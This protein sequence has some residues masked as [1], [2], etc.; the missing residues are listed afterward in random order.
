MPA[1]S[2]RGTIF[3]D[4][5]GL[6]GRP[7]LMPNPWDVYTARLFEAEGYQALGTSSA[8]AAW[9]IGRRDGRLLRDEA[10]AHARSIAAAVTVPVSAD[11]ENGFSDRPEDLTELMRLASEAGLAG[12]S[13]EDATG[14]P[15]EP[16]YA[17]SHAVERIAAAAE[18]VRSLRRPFVLTARSENFL[19]GIH[20]LEDTIARLQAFERAGADV[21]FA[22]A[23]PS[24]E[25][26][27]EVVRSVSAPVSFMV[28]VQGRSFSVRDLADAGV[29]RISFGTCLYRTAAGAIRAAA[30]EVRDRGTFQFLDGA[31]AYPELQPRLDP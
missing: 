31:L 30:R 18:A 3:Q 2:A 12:A 10:L 23:L 26:V 14:K 13:L 4:L 7:L 11:L 8:A 27:R 15:T 20:N 9:T 21:L 1:N 19:R 16:V 24:L 17:F 22:P 28:G 6:P 5:H 25:A 29:S